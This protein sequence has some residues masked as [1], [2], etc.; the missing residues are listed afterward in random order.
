MAINQSL[1]LG[2]ERFH[3]RIERMTGRRREVKPRGT[4]TREA[5][6]N[7]VLLPWQGEFGVVIEINAS[8][9]PY[10]AAGGQVA[11]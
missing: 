1:A 5:P 11:E 10:N 3:A 6:T 4:P 8:V 2:N 9:A 7:D